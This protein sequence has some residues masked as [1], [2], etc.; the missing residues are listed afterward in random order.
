VVREL[1]DA[2]YQ[3]L[4]I[5]NTQVMSDYDILE[6]TGEAYYK[7]AALFRE[8]MEGCMEYM[9]QLRES[10][11]TIMNSVSDIASGIQV[12]TD[13]VQENTQNIMD[14]QTQIG[15]VTS[16]VEENEKVIQSLNDL[17]GEFKL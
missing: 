7:D 6:H 10:M 11:D 1:S 5:V 15:A 17:L 14:I 13:V 4:S 8:Q 2:A 16:S 9:K 12:E 3:L